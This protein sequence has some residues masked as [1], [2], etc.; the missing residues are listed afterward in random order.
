MKTVL[1]SLI[2]FLVASLSISAQNGTKSIEESFNILR[3]K[4]DVAFFEVSKEMFEM[5]AESET[6]PPELK[7]YYKQLTNLKMIENQSSSRNELQTLYEP[8]L[9]QTNLKGFNRLMVSERSNEKISFM[10]NKTKDGKNEFLLISN[11]TVI[12][13]LGEIDLKSIH[14]FEMVLKIAGNA[15]GR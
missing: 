4:E 1:L 3:A 7:T 6:T 8:F 11:K 2:V 15:L 14:E 13:I 12:Y 10:K 9:S 5:L